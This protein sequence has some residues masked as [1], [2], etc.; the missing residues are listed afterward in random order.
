MLKL[1]MNVHFLIIYTPLLFMSGDNSCLVQLGE[2]APE[3]PGN[4]IIQADVPSHDIGLYLKYSDRLLYAS[5]IVLMTSMAGLIAFVLSGIIAG[6][7]VCG[8]VCGL[9]V[10][11]LCFAKVLESVNVDAYNRRQNE[12]NRASRSELQASC[13]SYGRYYTVLDVDAVQDSLTSR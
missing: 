2:C 5:G 13:S 11:G 6:A 12:I 7:I 9:S 10:F 8:V 3:V 1:K 4:D